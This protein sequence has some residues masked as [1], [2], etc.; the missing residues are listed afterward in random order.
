MKSRSPQPVSA[1]STDVW[2]VGYLPNFNGVIYKT[3]V[4]RH[5]ATAAPDEEDDGPTVAVVEAGPTGLTVRFVPL[6]RR[7]M[8]ELNRRY[9]R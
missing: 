9:L 7:D 8:R 3:R 1:D 5:E 2:C 6:V 4:A